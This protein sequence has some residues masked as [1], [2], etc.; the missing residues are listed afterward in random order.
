VRKK[1]ERKNRLPDEIIMSASAMQG[2]RKQCKLFHRFICKKYCRKKC[3]A[4]EKSFF[5]FD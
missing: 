4:N 5:A 3:W 1:E 2:G